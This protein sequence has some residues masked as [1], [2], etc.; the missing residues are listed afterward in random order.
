MNSV[1]QFPPARAI[2]PAQTIEIPRKPVKRSHIKSPTLRRN[3]ADQWLYY[4]RSFTKLANDFEATE[5]AIENVLRA[6]VFH[7]HPPN[8]PSARRAA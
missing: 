5:K 8:T 1:T 4:G 7:V 3:I 2:R 6:D